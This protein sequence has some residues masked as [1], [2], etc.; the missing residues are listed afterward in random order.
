MVVT[1]T[2]IR[3]AEGGHLECLKWA[4]EHG[5]PWNRVQCLSMAINDSKMLEWIESN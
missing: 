3:A 5:C 4:R 2:Q 1:G